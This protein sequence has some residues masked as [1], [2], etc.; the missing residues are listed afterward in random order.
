MQSKYSAARL[1]T[2]TLVAISSLVIY[3]GISRALV[4]PMAPIIKIR[5]LATLPLKE[6]VRKLFAKSINCPTV[7]RKKKRRHKKKYTRRHQEQGSQ[8][9]MEG[10]ARVERQKSVSAHY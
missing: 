1:N 9:A 10:Q 7:W 3:G 4:T 2:I 8:R 5:Q 6:N